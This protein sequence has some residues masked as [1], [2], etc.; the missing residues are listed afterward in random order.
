[1]KD[2]PDKS[3]S[4]CP[5]IRSAG[6]TDK[7]L[8]RDANED[9]FFIDEE[10]GVFVVSDGMGGHQ[11]GATASR[12][13]VSVLPNILRQRL[14][15]SSSPRASNLKAT[16][17][18]AIVD[19]SRMVREHTEGHPALQGMGATVVVVIIRAEAL[20]VANM[21]DSRGYRLR[22]GK[23]RQLSIDHSLAA[24]LMRQR[25]IS[26]RNVREHPGRTTLT[27]YVGM[28]SEV[29]PDVRS[30]PLRHGDRILLCSDG[31]TGVL[32]D[33]TIATILQHYVEVETACRALVAAANEA[34]ADDNI[35]VVIV[36]YG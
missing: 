11:A 23:L 29:Y 13:V 8:V 16:I 17:R 14:G 3:D 34:G 26:F 7:G 1:M 2:N 6:L 32:E 20:Y 25:E 15:Q 31:L 18:T 35:T 21:G 28:P 36:D 22:R 10:A 33:C 30:F 19:L 24:L 5:E 12:I 27:R 4:E 9:A